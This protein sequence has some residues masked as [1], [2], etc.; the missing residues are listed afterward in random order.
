MIHISEVAGKWVRDIRKF[1]KPDKTYVVKVLHVNEEN[2]HI[3][4]SLKRVS[5][6]EK[7]RKMQEFR[8]EQ[9]AEK[10]L[11]K[12]GKKLKLNLNEAYKKIG[13]EL[14]DK[15]GSMFEAF[16]S[17]LTSEEPLINK[18]IPKNLAKVIHEI[19][20][21]NIKK[22]KVKIKA[23]LN[24]RFFSGDGIKKVKNF[25]NGLINKYG[26]TIK[27]ISAPRYRVE[28]ESDNPKLAGKEL[29][30]WLTDAVAKIKDGEADFKMV[31]R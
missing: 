11:E 3:S 23:E 10:M 27:Y 13:Y 6:I 31:E 15:F 18:G 9:K 30:K 29:K 4:L 22:K 17:A 26:V 16:N 21:E 2:G 24:L 7:T 28:I 25:L 12:V 19:A 1:I 5:R 8:L 20:K 14:Q